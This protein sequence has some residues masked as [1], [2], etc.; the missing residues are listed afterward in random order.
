MASFVLSP[1]VNASD[2]EQPKQKSKN[3]CR[4]ATKRSGMA[5][6]IRSNLVIYVAV[7]PLEPNVSSLIFFPLKDE[8]IKVEIIFVFSCT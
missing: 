6:R 5:G 1:F 8:A 3:K 2:N 7:L 4:S